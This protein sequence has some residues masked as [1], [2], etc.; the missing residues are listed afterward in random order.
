MPTLPPVSFDTE[1]Q[2]C[3]LCSSD[4]LREYDR[5]FEDFRIDRCA[6]CGVKLMN[7]Q[8]TDEYLTEY[9]RQY[10][11][12]LPVHSKSKKAEND[13]SNSSFRKRRHRAKVQQMELISQHATPGR[14]L[15]VGCG[16]GLE[17]VMA[18]ENGW[19]AEGYEINPGFAKQVASVLGVPIHSGDFCHLELGDGS[20]DCVY[21]DQVIE[22]LKSPQE[23]LRTANRLLRVGGLLYIGCPN[24]ASLSN[25]W[26]TISGRLGLQRRRGRHYDLCKH[27]FYFSPGVLTN[28][29][30]EQYQFEVL[31]CEGA[32][33]SGTKTTSAGLLGRIQ[34]RLVQKFPVLDSTF[35]F[36]ARK[37]ADC[38]PAQC[39]TRA[40]A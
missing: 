8:C 37:L 29:V 13:S 18:Q 33:L 3:P 26:K 28:V 15:S 7:P 25:S 10:N 39:E 16:D 30:Q 9:Y 1:L 40:A 22:H 2:A 11:Q 17:V 36:V 27:L 19:E 24:I 20:Y 34:E 12:H 5:T 31:V 38:T 23:Y 32:P 6:Q 21:M 14:F 35:H 4:K